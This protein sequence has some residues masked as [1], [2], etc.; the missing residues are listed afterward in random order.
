MIVC[1]SAVVK[2]A[3]GEHVEQT[4]PLLRDGPAEGAESTT[5]VPVEG[6]VSFGKI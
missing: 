1:R 3:L 6:P 2:L 5:H 4:F